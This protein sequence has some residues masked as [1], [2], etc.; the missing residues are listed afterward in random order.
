M[1][2]A[3]EMQH[4]V[5]HA[6][7]PAL[8][9]ANSLIHNLP[10]RV[11]AALALTWCDI[12][13]ERE[14]RIVSKRTAECLLGA[15]ATRRYI[16]AKIAERVTNDDAA[17]W[18]FIRDLDTSTPYDLARETGLFFPRLRD[19]KSE[20]E[21]VREEL[22]VDDPIFSCVDLDVLLGGLHG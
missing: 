21:G 9:A 22:A 5:Q 14:A 6:S 8:W 4:F 3:H 19:Y 12:P 1:T 11:I 7:V 16:D 15:E 17:D 10:K 2:F 18:Q 13:H 20:L